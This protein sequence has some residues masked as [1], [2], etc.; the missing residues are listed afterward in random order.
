M[1]HR[2]VRTLTCALM[3]L[4]AV[5]APLA[6]TTSANASTPAAVGALP[7]ASGTSWRARA[8]GSYAKT[9]QAAATR[10]STDMV[11]ANMARASGTVNGWSSS[12]TVGLIRTAL[13]HKHPD[14]GFGVPYAFDPFSDGTSNPATTGYTV[15]TADHVGQLLIE[16]YRKGRVSRYHVESVRDWL[17]TV[18]RATTSRG[19]CVAYSNSP[20]DRTI[21]RA[22]GSIARCVHNVN[23][24]T[25]MYL[26]QASQLGMTRPGQLELARDIMRYSG[27]EV[28]GS[29]RWPYQTGKT[30]PQD[31]DHNSLNVEAQKVFDPV[32]SLTTRTA[33]AQANAPLTADYTDHLGRLRATVATKALCAPAY[34]SSLAFRA[35]VDALGTTSEGRTTTI[36]TIRYSQAA[37]WEARNIA[38]CGA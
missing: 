4:A 29:G 2:S 17:M 13:A 10:G 32:G 25:A 23:A 22:D 27:R 36:T 37:L 18:P 19:T 33:A 34:S 28:L 9:Q 16:G 7:A 31:L 38:L 26:V 3:T 8:V 12:T 30:T 6:A 14:G 11:W 24:S 35:R 5:A 15:T 20:N 21:A 1:Q